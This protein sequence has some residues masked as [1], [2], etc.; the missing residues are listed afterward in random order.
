MIG[1]IG[2]STDMVL[3]WLGGVLFPWKRRTR[4]SAGPW[5]WLAWLRPATI[6]PVALVPEEPESSGTKPETELNVTHGT[7]TS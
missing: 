1:V 7:Q 5:A 3:A 6:A 4:T 2:L